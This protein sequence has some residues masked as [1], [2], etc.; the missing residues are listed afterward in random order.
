MWGYIKSPKYIDYERLKVGVEK[1]YEKPF[2]EC[3]K[4]RCLFKNE[5]KRNLTF[6]SRMQYDK[7]RVEYGLL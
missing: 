5:V 7:I 2:G 4:L 1:C 3:E 6:F